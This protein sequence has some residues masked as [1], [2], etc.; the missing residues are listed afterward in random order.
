MH[1]KQVHGKQVHGKQAGGG[2]GRVNG[3]GTATSARRE[4]QSSGPDCIRMLVLML[5]LVPR[6]ARGSRGEE[7]P[8][9][10]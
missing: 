7:R 9:D 6:K 5:V 3:Q 10:S 1:G 4:Q 2:G 8:P